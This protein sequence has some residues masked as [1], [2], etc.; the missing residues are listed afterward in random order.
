MRETQVELVLAAQRIE[1]A[2]HRS[3]IHVLVAAALELAQQRRLENPFNVTGTSEV[4]NSGASKVFS[5]RVYDRRAFQPLKTVLDLGE[6]F[7][8]IRV[9]A[10]PLCAHGSA[11]PLGQSISLP[12]ASSAGRPPQLMPRGRERCTE[13][14]ALIVVDSPISASTMPYSTSASCCRDPSCRHG[15]LSRRPGAPHRAGG[16][17]R[18]RQVDLA[19]IRVVAAGRDLGLPGIH[20]S[21]AC[22]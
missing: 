20:A 21:D 14:P 15:A 17:E 6:V 11:G 19:P 10:R 2:V 13:P 12:E 16:V 8:G 5:S 22:G 18:R 4:N 3:A 9:P 7:M 1:R